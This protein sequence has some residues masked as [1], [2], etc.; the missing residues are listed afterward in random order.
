LQ[1]G[2]LI[3]GHET[4]KRIFI[5]KLKAMK[6][7]DIES[8]QVDSGF[9]SILSHPLVYQTYQ[10][11]VGID[12]AFKKYIN[13]IIKPEG[14]CRILDIGCGE[15]YILNFLP[16]NVTYVGYDMSP[17]YINYAKEKFGNRG[18]FINERVSE[19]TMDSHSS[20][21]IVLAT[22]LLHHLSDE[23]GEELFRIG[24]ACLRPGGLMY[25][26]DN[27]FFTGQ[28]MLAR[29][30]SS[31]DRGQH[32][33]YPEQYRAIGLRAFNKVEI[34]VKHNMIRIP[35]TICILRCQKE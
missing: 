30:I 35:Q 14:N 26:Y 33:R 5:S 7:A 15:G 28:S 22:G 4:I 11:L 9:R 12:I 18:M 34:I 2:S 29:Y 16:E 23:E 17:S 25:T 8:D 20:F 3:A 1:Y 24:T 31:K 10:R 13:E 19:M 32:V 21:D 6:K 27:A